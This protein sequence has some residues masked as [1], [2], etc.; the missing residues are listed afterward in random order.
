MRIVEVVHRLAF[1]DNKSVTIHNTEIHEMLVVNGITFILGREVK[2]L[3]EGDVAESELNSQSVLV[4]VLVEERA[5]LF[6]HLLTCS[7]D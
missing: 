5:E 2:L 7:N 1:N 6:V 4:H 3:V